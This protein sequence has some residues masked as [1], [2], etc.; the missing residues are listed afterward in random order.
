[1]F[2]DLLEFN[3]VLRPGRYGVQSIIISGWL[4]WVGGGGRISRYAIADKKTIKR[5]SS[6]EPPASHTAPERMNHGVV[7]VLRNISA[8]CLAICVAVGVAR[9]DTRFTALLLPPFLYH[10]SIHTPDW[11][12]KLPVVLLLSKLVDTV[13]SAIGIWPARVMLMSAGLALGLHLNGQLQ[14]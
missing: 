6:P 12:N 8:L 2:M 3:T 7:Q 9:Y 5:A 4:V 10:Y 11:F 13:Q 1:M 14:L